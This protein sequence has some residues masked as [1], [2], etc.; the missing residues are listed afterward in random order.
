[1]LAERHACVTGSDTV[2][3]PM[4][5]GFD[6]DPSECSRVNAD[7][8]P[9]LSLRNA[10]QSLSGACSIGFSNLAGWS[11][12]LRRLAAVVGV[13]SAIMPGGSGFFASAGGGFFLSSAAF[14]GGP[15][16][17]SAP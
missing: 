13:K 9:Y 2:A 6:P 12:S 10:R 8:T 7:G 1:M 14:A 4:A 17:A 16:P 11:S 15:S 5:N 3:S